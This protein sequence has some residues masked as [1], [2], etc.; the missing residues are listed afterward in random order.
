MSTVMIGWSKMLQKWLTLDIFYVSSILALPKGDSKHIFQFNSIK[1]CTLFHTKLST[2]Q[3]HFLVTLSFHFCLKTM[4]LPMSDSKFSF[5]LGVTFP[6]E[7]LEPWLHHP[8][9]LE[10]FSLPIEI[11][12]PS[13]LVYAFFPAKWSLPLLVI[14]KQLVDHCKKTQIV[15]P[16]NDLAEPNT[17]SMNLKWLNVLHL[18][19]KAKLIAKSIVIVINTLR[20]CLSNCDCSVAWKMDIKCE[21][22]LQIF[23][24]CFIWKL[25]K[26]ASKMQTLGRNAQTSLIQKCCPFSAH[27]GE[28]FGLVCFTWFWLK[29]LWMISQ[30]ILQNFKFL[31]IHWL[32]H[33]THQVFHRVKLLCHFS[34]CHSQKPKNQSLHDFVFVFPKNSTETSCSHTTN[35][36]WV[37][38]LECT[39][40]Q[41][42]ALFLSQV[43]WTTITH[44][45]SNACKFCHCLHITSMTCSQKFMSQKYNVTF[46]HL[47]T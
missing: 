22:N 34:L 42:L 39:E 4:A 5:K 7:L 41:V 15:A 36:N 16:V 43:E 12:P 26:M 6:N 9:L 46:H 8:V 40:K 1:N 29:K 3:H 33:F 10:F 27:F 28:P 45:L 14:Y 11:V 32:T 35:Q 20:F 17:F 44:W 31:W 25:I 13:N 19:I 30:V 2:I 23:P 24:Q 18:W 47:S 37:L 21:R 38:Q